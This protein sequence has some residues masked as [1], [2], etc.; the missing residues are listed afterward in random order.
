MRKSH[1]RHKKQQN[2]AELGKKLLWAELLF[3][4]N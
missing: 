2:E 3:Y 1:V 4:L